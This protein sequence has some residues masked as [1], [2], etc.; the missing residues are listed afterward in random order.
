MRLAWL[1]VVVALAT[2]GCKD[3]ADGK[4]QAATAVPDQADQDLLA[5]R[6]ALLQSREQL[7][8]QKTQ[9]QVQIDEAKKTGA[10][11]LELETQ[12]AK[13]SSEQNANQD[14]LLEVFKRQNEAYKIQLEALRGQGGSDRTEIAA[15]T[16]QL[17]RRDGQ[18]ADMEKKLVGLAGQLTDI[19]ADIQKQAETCSTGGGTTI[20]QAGKTSGSKYNKRDVEPLLTKARAV[21]SKRGIQMSDLPSYV[22]KLEKDATNAM[23]SG[24]Y[25]SAYFT[26][27][28]F[29]EEVDKVKI[30]KEF[31]AEKIAR[32]NRAVKAK[33]LDDNVR[34]QV[35]DLFNKVGD[36]FNDG[37]HAG[38]NR[39]LNDI[40]ALI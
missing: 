24:D 2:A 35:L 31:V 13:L 4:A 7:E 8:E 11:T 36:K 23:A 5:R 22:G 30:N 12:L 15:L 10:D 3:K 33:K 28:S 6:D 25:N 40:L 21:M 1:G 14:E 16:A 9:L 27:T 17:Q 32:L 19:R 18:L 38:A 29:Y 39:A 20:I 37:D 34:K 26:A